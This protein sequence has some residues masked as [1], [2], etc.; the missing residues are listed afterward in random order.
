MKTIL[1][2]FFS[3][4]QRS[5]TVKKNIIG[6]LCIKGCSIIISLMLVPM[7]LGYVSSEL[8]GIWLTLSSIMMWL[9]FFDV[10]FTL[11]LK[12]KLAE[13]IALEEWEKGK[14]LVSTTYFMMI[15]IFVPLCLILM[16]CVPFVNWANFLNV[17]PNYNS[18]IS[19]TL[20]VL[21]ACFCLQMIVNVLISI[22]AAYQKVAL[23]SIFPVIGNFLSLIAIFLLTPLCPPSLLILSFAISTMPIIVIIIGSIILFKSK[24]KKISPSIKSINTQYIK[25]LLNLGIKFFLLQIQVVILYQCTNILISNVSGPNDV[26]AYNISYK[27]LGIAMMLYTII[28]TPLWPAFTDAYT[29]KD[30]TWMKNTYKKMT[31]ILYISILGIFI[32]ILISPITY[33]LWIGNKATISYSMTISVGIYMAI[34][35]WHTLQVELINGIGSIKLQTYITLIGTIIYIPL[36]II[37]GN[38]IGAIGVIY[39]MSI[40]SS[41]YAIIFTIQIKKL[42]NKTAK[43]IWIQ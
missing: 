32:M 20:Y 11:G 10:G 13:A 19:K 6:S 14:S 25:E 27:Y 21:I 24:F 35:S 1:N 39:S 15:L 7:T 34:H 22:I 33:E 5:V 3:G 31:H 9:N 42:L 17:N 41:I 18:D 30:F 43:G 29:K 36:A 38:Y 4:N 12:N 8:Y 28:L 40:I 37:L 16:T 26:T 2:K 23:S